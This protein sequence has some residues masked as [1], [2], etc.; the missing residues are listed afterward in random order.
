M[1]KVKLGTIVNVRGLKGEVKIMSTSD[2][3][4]L[5]YKKG[6]KILISNGKL[7]TFLTCEKFSK[8][9]NFDYV[10]FNE[11]KDVESA[12]KYRNFDVYYLVEDLPK[13]EEGNFYYYQ[14]EGLDCFDLDNNF[15]GKVIS[16]DTNT[17]Q[18]LLRIKNETKEF[19]VPFVKSF[20]IEVRLAENK[21]I[22]NNMEGLI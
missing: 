6:N 12:N 17:V 10:I 15:L 22:I 1:E 18:K 9:G 3:S 2:F 13:L 20:I 11:I 5:R 16:I 7:D 19:L 14:L 4:S 21:I 8:V